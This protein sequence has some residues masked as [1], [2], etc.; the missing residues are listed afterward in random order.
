MGEYSKEGL[1]ELLKEREEASKLKI[2]KGWLI[3]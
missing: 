2:M 1:V 3:R